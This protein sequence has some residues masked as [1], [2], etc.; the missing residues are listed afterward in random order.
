M[1]LMQITTGA[2]SRPRSAPPPGGRNGHIGGTKA[3]ETQSRT[4]TPQQIPERVS[5][6]APRAT[7]TSTLALGPKPELDQN[8][9][10]AEL[11]LDPGM[12]AHH[13]ETA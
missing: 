5:S 9:I 1:P 7:A 11:A 10:N 8:R 13:I 3:R 4:P 12:P 6:I 2:A